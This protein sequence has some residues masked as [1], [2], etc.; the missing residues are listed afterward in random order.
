[1]SSRVGQQIKMAS[2]DE[3]LGAP[4]MDGS[5]E[6][7][8][9]AI[10][11]FEN[12]PFRVVDDEKMDDLVES[13]KL[14]GILTPVLVRPDDKGTY[15][16]VSGHRRLH[17]AR[18]AGLLK[19]PALVREL[20]I[21]EATILMVDANIQREEILPSEKAF[22]LKM[23]MDAIKHQ[24]KKLSKSLSTEWTMKRSGDIVGETEGIAKSQVHKYIRLT[25]LIPALLEMVDKK[26]LALSVAVELSYL[27]RTFQQW[28]YEYIYEKGMIKQ[29]QLMELRA[30]RGKEGLTREQ[31]LTVLDESR[32]CIKRSPKV[33]LS[34]RKLSKFFPAYYS[35]DEMEG[36]IFELLAKWKIENGV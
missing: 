36:I 16:M 3:L 21:A 14:N 8:I 12:H 29:E 25:E 31:F 27:S 28:S 26:R 34:G 35:R 9:R 4:D 19:I 6:I 2:I 23:K 20:T 32:A 30:Y 5:I 15:E 11:P 7:D 17:A 1:M 22:A 18:R 13:I 24:G 33:T 10:Y